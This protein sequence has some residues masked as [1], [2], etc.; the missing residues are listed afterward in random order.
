MTKAKEHKH[1]LFLKSLEVT[2]VSYPILHINKAEM[3][4]EGKELGSE[5]KN[6]ESLFKF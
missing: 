2:Q 4:Q 3:S 6:P 5:F 1:F